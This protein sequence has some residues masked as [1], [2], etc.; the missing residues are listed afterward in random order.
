MLEVISFLCVCLLCYSYNW[1]PVAQVLLSVQEKG[2]WRKESSSDQIPT[3]QSPRK[4]KQSSC[5]SIPLYSMHVIICMGNDG[6]PRDRS[7]AKSARLRPYSIT[8]SDSSCY[9]V[10][11][12]AVCGCLMTCSSLPSDL[13]TQSGLHG[14]ERVCS[15]KDR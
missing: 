3:Y 5:C 12:L 15:H 9:T 2:H 6:V 1:Y 14:G 7:L 4:R 10:Y 13:A 11:T 8:E